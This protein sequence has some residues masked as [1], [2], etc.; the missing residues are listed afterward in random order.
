M[1][2]AALRLELHL[3]DGSTRRRKRRL[4]EEILD[5]LRRHFNVSIAEVD[6]DDRPDRSILGVAAV[7]ASG[8]EAREVLE[9]VAEAVEAHPSV[10]IVRLAFREF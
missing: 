5:K 3:S 1:H 9:R 8:K 2:V 4:M 6:A 7:A 10:E